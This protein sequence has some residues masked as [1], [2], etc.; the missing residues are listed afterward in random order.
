MRTSPIP[1]T[2]NPEVMQ[3]TM[4]PGMAAMQV[5]C[6][7]LPSRKNL[8]NG[9]PPAAVSTFW[10]CPISEAV[11]ML[12]L[13]GHGLSMTRVPGAHHF[14]PTWDRQSKQPRVNQESG[15]VRF[16]SWSKALHTHSCCMPPSF[17]RLSGLHCRFLPFSLSHFLSRCD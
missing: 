2:E 3:G 6:L 7:T 14:C 9:Q 1:S 11:A 16:A 15:S 17:P 8:P 13:R 12:A 4:T 10:I 5:H